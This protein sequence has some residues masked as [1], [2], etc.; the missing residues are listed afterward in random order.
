MLPFPPFVAFR[1]CRL[2]V[3]QMMNRLFNNA[4]ADNLGLLSMQ[5]N[6]YHIVISFLPQPLIEID[7]FRAFNWDVLSTCEWWGDYQHSLHV[8]HSSFPPT[9]SLLDHSDLLT[10]LC[11]SLSWI[12]ISKAHFRNSHRFIIQFNSSEAQNA[13]WTNTQH[14]T[15]SVIMNTHTHSAGAFKCAT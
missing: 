13:I 11:K 10:F 12:V 9:H 8:L 15:W 1:S 7:R 2:I 5:L 14:W 3:L 6:T 4:V